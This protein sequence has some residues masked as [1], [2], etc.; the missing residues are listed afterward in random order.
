MKR[1]LLS[2]LLVSTYAQSSMLSSALFTHTKEIAQ[3]TTKNISWSMETTKEAVCGAIK[4]TLEPLA[5]FAYDNMTLA[6]VSTATI[7]YVAYKAGKFV[8]MP[9]Y[10]E[11]DVKQIVV[12]AK[13]PLAKKLRP[14][15][16]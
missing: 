7:A 3:E 11:E 2:L 5:T 4:V 16:T 14:D 12:I 15:R 13:A 9:A 10:K 6:A 1:I 8:H